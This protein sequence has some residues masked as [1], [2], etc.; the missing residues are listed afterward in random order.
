MILLNLGEVSDNCASSYDN[1]YFHSCV[2]DGNGA[3]VLTYSDIV[4]RARDQSGGNIDGIGGAIITRSNEWEVSSTC[5]YDAE[6]NVESMFHTKGED[7]Y[8]I[9][10]LHAVEFSLAIYK[11]QTFSET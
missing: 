11:D 5:R 1:M 10:D 7:G 4:T 2:S 8:V 6:D 9:A 3:H